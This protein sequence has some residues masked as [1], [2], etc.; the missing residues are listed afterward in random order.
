MCSRKKSDH[1]PYLLGRGIIVRLIGGLWDDVPTH[2]RELDGNPHPLGRGV[3]P[4]LS[5]R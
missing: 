4:S 5:L 3:D 1:D 2:T